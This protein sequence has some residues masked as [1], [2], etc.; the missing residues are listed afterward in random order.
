[1]QIYAHIIIVIN[2]NLNQ[3]Y[4]V[5]E[6]F[7]FQNFESKTDT[8]EDFIEI[9]NTFFSCCRKLMFTVYTIFL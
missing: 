5:N 4:L 8:G 3:L 2:F 6:S 9:V 7:L 1:M